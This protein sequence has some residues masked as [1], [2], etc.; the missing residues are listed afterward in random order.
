MSDWKKRAEKPSSN[1]GSDWKSRASIEDNREPELTEEMHPSLTWTDRAIIKNL[2]NA[3]DEGTE[4]NIKFLQS[5]HPDLEFKSINGRIAAKKPDEAQWKALDPDTGF[6]SKDIGHD[7]SDLLAD[8]ATG[9]AEGAGTALGAV[10][11]LP[12]MMAGAASGSALAESLRQY[13]GKYHGVNPEMNWDDVKTNAAIAGAFPVAGRVAKSAYNF[14]T[15]KA[16]PKLASWASGVPS[17]YIEVTGKRLNEM[18][19]LDRGGVSNLV[20]NAYEKIYDPLQQGLEATGSELAQTIDNAGGKVD[21]SDAKQIIGDLASKYEKHKDNLD[22]KELKE[23]IGDIRGT[24][25]RLFGTNEK[26][27]A[28]YLA[29]K[30]PAEQ[31]EILKSLN[32]QVK[33]EPSPAQNIGDILY[34]FQP[35]HSKVQFVTNEIPNKIPASDAWQLQKQMGHLA[36]QYKLGSTPSLV[37][38]RTQGLPISEK[39]VI[40]G[41]DKGKASIDQGLTNTTEGLSRSL[42]DRYQSIAKLRDKLDAHFGNEQQTYASLRNLDKVSKS[43][44]RDTLEEAKNLGIDV[45]KDAELLQAH[46]IMGEP[47]HGLTF[48]KGLPMSP[49]SS[50]GVTSTSR[51]LGT[52]AL[53]ASAG[54][55]LGNEMADSPKAGAAIGG[56]LASLAGSPWAIKKYI[57]S[58]L[59]AE[60]NASK[61][62][63]TLRYAIPEKSESAQSIWELIKS[64]K[65]EEE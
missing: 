4:Q 8:A 3:G 60:R 51:S 47:V 56:T 17:Q 49:I 37:S 63:R 62:P 21:V 52:T 31:D 9:L 34:G 11:G 42:K 54:A 29:N 44:L 26:D 33:G 6:F 25:K 30:T 19:E 65:N 48:A 24:Y 2:S 43:T 36:R 28:E 5:R 7:T 23:A 46:A 27:I 16:F 13:F 35:N 55:F 10:A 41:L 18:D 59:K 50:Q 57:R 53:G 32:I 1:T 15:R 61:I 64:L 58:G 45:S 40:L 39:E 20:K 12:G 14:G 22:N 38:P